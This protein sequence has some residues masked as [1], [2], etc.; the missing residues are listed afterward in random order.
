[1]NPSE[2]ITRRDLM[3]KLLSVS[4]ATV[5]ATLVGGLQ[6][7]SAEE[8]NSPQDEIA[9]IENTIDAQA[10]AGKW[11]QVNLAQQR[12]TAW[13]GGSAYLSSL[14]STGTAR[15]PTVRGTF[16]VYVKYVA[17]R[18]RGPGYDLPNVPYTMYF[19]R[20]YGLH[21]TY[22]HHNFGHPMSHGCVNLPTPIARQVFNWAPVGTP[23]VVS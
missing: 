10:R 11:I 13:N 15:Y 1:M 12:M 18:M 23:V 5:A 20:G 7:V 21:G 19:Y 8:T 16:R 9:S 22:W 3:K 14:C 4:G 17:T 2:L 6:I